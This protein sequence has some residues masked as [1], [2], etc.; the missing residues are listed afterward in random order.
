VKRR[1]VS[2]RCALSVGLVLA[3][4][5]SLV[6]CKGK[7]ESGDDGGGGHASTAVPVA[8]S[9]FGQSFA[10]AYCAIG[11]CCQ[12]EGYAFT[13]SCEAT[14]KAYV[15]SRVTESLQKPG[16]S[17]D[18]ASAGTCVEAY[19]AAVK[20]CTDRKLSDAVD[21]ACQHLFRGTVPEGGACTTDQACADIPGVSYVQCDTGVCK[22]G[23][24]SSAGSE[25]HAKLGEPCAYTCEEDEFGLGCS[26]GSGTT[27]PQSMAG[28]YQNDGLYCTKAFVCAPLPK[29]GESCPEYVCALDSYC[30]GSTC[31]ARTATGPCPNYDECLHTSYCDDSTQMCTPLKANGSACNLSDECSSDHCA[32]DACRE[33]SVASASACAG[34]LDD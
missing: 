32:E 3:A 9:S 27:T 8:A 29:A 30:N 7:S 1:R 13:S 33:W 18:E 5:C 26:S 10:T 17:F 31:V 15:D 19:G 4:A 20:A 23:T 11:A 28:C 25:V 34:L 12:R 21:D 24:N 16:V 14:V 2:A 6:G 22:R